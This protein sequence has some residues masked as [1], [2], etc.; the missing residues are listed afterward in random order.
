[1]TELNAVAAELETARRYTMLLMSACCEYVRL[2][3]A[4]GDDQRATTLA[5]LLEDAHRRNEVAKL[6]AAFM[7]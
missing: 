3:A 2:V 5:F 7:L 6:H 1:M 4:E